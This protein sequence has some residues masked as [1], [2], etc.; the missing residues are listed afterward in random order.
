M[1]KHKKPPAAPPSE[2]NL[3]AL[4]RF[5]RRTTFHD[6]VIEEITAI[7]QRVILRFYELTLVVTGVTEFKRCE[8]IPTAWITHR[9]TPL[10]GGFRMEVETEESRLSVTGKDVRLIRNND[11]AMLIPPID[12]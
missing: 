5:W 8:E 12:S 9:M 7:H 1:N 10:P 6:M 4:E 2:S 3:E 11:L